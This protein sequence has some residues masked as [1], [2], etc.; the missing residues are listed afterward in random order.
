MRIKTATKVFSAILLLCSAPAWAEDD[1]APEGAAASAAPT[2]EVFG[3]KGQFVPSGSLSFFK[4]STSRPGASSTGNVNFTLAPS[5]G[6]FVMNNL[7]IGVNA[8]VQYVTL[9]S[10]SG[11]L[12]ST[13]VT[14]IGGG[15]SAGYNISFTPK[16]SLLPQLSFGVKS[17]SIDMPVS[18]SSTATASMLMTQL[19]IFVPILWH[20]VPHFFLGVGPIFR[21][22]LTSSI[23]ENGQSQDYNKTTV[24]GLQTTIG[25]WL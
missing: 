18:S 8:A 1:A 7:L 4:N 22:D 23:K 21:T 6:Y 16:A 24:F 14:L 20:P 13:S 10:S 17:T 15:L 25:G 5:L 3:G 19:E 11:S 12:S 2:A 9:D